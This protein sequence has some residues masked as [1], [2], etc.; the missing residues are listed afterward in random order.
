TTGDPIN[1]RTQEITC[2]TITLNAINDV[3]LAPAHNTPS[4]ETQPF[5][6]GDYTIVNVDGGYQPTVVVCE[7][8]D[9]VYDA[10]DAIRAKGDPVSCS[11]AGFTGDAIP[12][13]SAG[14][15]I[16]S[17]QVAVPTRTVTMSWSATKS[18]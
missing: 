7:Y 2:G 14:P 16:Q 11:L 6:G 18:V 3:P 4:T 15:T 9:S 12:S 13:V 17:N 1:G 10:L 5:Q 8:S